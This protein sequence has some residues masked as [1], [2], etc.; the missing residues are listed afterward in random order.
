MK[1]KSTI[2]SNASTSASPPPPSRQQQQQ[3]Q[4]KLKLY[5]FDIKGRGESI[6]LLSAYA[7]LEMEDFRYTEPKQFI[8]MKENGTL[9]FEQVP[10]LEIDDGKH[11]IPQSSAILRYLAKLGGLYPKDPILAAKVD[12]ALDQEADAFLGPTVATYH[13]RYGI[14]LNDEGLAKTAY[15]IATETMPQHLRCIDR[16][17]AESS[18]GWI[19]G[20]EEPSPADFVWACRLVHYLPNQGNFFS[21]GLGKLEGFPHCKKFVDK[22]MALPQIKKYYEPDSDEEKE[23]FKKARTQGI[24]EES[25]E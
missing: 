2:L 5:Y 17:L 23:N 7:G 24:D 18:T 8:E 20:T 6:R 22:F 14:V 15:L 1:R 11:R 13:R 3:K 21:E 25:K 10:M 9:P 16:L 12:A 19:A 4:P